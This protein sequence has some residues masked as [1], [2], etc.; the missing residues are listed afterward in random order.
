[1]LVF[2]VLFALA[3]SVGP[4]T[5]QSL[6]VRA[7]G[8]GKSCFVTVYGELVT[9]EALRELARTHGKSAVLEAD[10]RTSNRCFGNAIV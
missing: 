6:Q 9:D 2:M 5:T 1:V 4:P 3:G 8:E 10:R 7:A